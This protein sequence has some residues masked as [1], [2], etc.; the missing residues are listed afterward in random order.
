MNKYPWGKVI[1]IFSIPIDEYAL[2]ITKYHPFQFNGSIATRTIDETKVVYSCEETCQS[3]DTM[4]QL[5]LSW[6]VYKQ[7]GMNQSALV[8][9]L[10]RMLKL[11]DE[12]E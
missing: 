8:S 9:G 6:I 10:A 5:I 4:M 11:G 3:A 12:N 7:L 2:V 1:T